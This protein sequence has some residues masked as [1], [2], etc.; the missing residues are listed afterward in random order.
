VVIVAA[1]LTTGL[2]PR[3]AI[4]ASSNEQIFAVGT[5]EF[6]LAGAHGWNHDIPSGNRT[7]VKFDSLVFKYG[8]FAARTREVAVEVGGC[9][10]STQRGDADG[11]GASLLFRRYIVPKRPIAV[12]CE[13]GG[14]IEYTGLILP[15][16]P[17]RFNTTLQAG[18]GVNL[19]SSDRAAL[20]LTCRFHHV[21][22]GGRKRPNVGL[23]SSM[24]LVGT[25]WFF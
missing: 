17:L 20:T 14:G 11:M 19:F 18:V 22:N 16:L 12:F 24:L 8:R 4:A 6:A 10:V 25:S 13:A 1:L 3:T 7:D 21:S 23:N 9:H 5:R 2:A 15:E